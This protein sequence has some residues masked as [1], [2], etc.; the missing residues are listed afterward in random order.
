MINP[1]HT[2]GLSL[3]TPLKTSET[4]GF[5][6][7]QKEISSMRCDSNLLVKDYLSLIEMCLLKDIFFDFGKV[8]QRW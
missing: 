2:T 3:L 7:V 6:E 1:F 8:A 4:R 5:E